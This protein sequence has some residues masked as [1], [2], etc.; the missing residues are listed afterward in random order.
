MLMANAKGDI[1]L[2]SVVVAALLVVMLLT[3]GALMTASQI[4]RLLGVTGLHV[5]TRVLGVLLCAL[6]VQF[7][8]HRGSVCGRAPQGSRGGALDRSRNETGTRG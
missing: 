1:G 3:F 4:Q 2:Q 5:I 6:A 8:V 7:I